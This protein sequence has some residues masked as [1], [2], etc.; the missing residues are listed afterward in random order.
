M[1]QFG[2]GE[3]KAKRWCAPIYAKLARKS[4]A[5]YAAARLFSERKI[6]QK[7]WRRKRLNPVTY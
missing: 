2:T 1:N 3:K 7:G 4:A 6:Q 5:A